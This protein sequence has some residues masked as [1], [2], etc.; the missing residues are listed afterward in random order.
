[1]DMAVVMSGSV[2]MRPL[3]PDDRGRLCR[4]YYRLSALSIY[5]RFASPIRAPR[6]D[7]LDRLMDVDHLDREAI[8]A[9]EGDEIVA[10]ARYIR[11][12]G[13]DAAEIAVV[14]Q[15]DWQRRGL[16]SL[17][18]RRLGRLARWRGIATF[19]GVALGENRPILKLLGRLGVGARFSLAAGQVEFEIPLR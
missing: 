12:P 17:L 4:L 16:G 6:A 19:T 7:M 9:L 10:V 5:R 15:D 14:V 1:M 13:R 8:A 11:L 3:R 18:L 2:R